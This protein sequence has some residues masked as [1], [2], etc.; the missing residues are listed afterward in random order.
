MTSRTRIFLVA[1]TIV[2][3]IGADQ[4]S[5]DIA[6]THLSKTKAVSVA[7]GALRFDYSENKGAV[8]S[9]E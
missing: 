4:I 8:F 1:F 2:L 3:A 6:R 9:F 5:K 7:D